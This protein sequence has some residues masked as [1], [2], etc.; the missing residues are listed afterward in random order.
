MASSDPD[1]A[2]PLARST[3]RSARVRPRIVEGLD[4]ALP[5][6]LELRAKSTERPS[7]PRWRPGL[8]SSDFQPN[9]LQLL[10]EMDRGRLPRPTSRR[11]MLLVPIW[12]RPRRNV[13]VVTT[14]VFAPNRR[15]F[16]RL[17]AADDDG[18]RS[19]NDQ[20]GSRC[21]GRSPDRLMLLEKGT[22]T[23]RRYETAVTLRAKR[24]NR[25]ALAPVEH[26][27]LDAWR[28]RSLA[29]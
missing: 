22:R 26:P 29:P 2:W 13:P 12:I 4:L 23:A 28:D 1:A 24:P 11:P 17:D 6:R 16:E 9:R 8:E 5:V 18:R 10:G 7:T 14:T 20:P 25:G 27:E 15:R 3:R 19:R 21:P